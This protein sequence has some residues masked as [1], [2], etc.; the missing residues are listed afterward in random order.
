MTATVKLSNVSYHIVIHFSVCGKSTW[1]L[2]S[3]QVSS[4][5][6]NMINNSYHAT[7]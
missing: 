6:Y 1:D 7:Q 4:I 2:V 5:Q 3:Y